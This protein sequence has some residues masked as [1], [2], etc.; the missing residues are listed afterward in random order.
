MNCRV[1]H[2]GWDFKDDTKLFKYDDYKVDLSLLHR[3]KSFNGI[4]TD[5]AKKENK[6]LVMSINSVQSSL[7]SH[8]CLMGNPVGKLCYQSFIFVELIYQDSLQSE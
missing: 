2:K 5:W 3:I 6:S 4:F 8:P 7:K 1:T